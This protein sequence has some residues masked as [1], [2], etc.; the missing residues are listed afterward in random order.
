MIKL[1]KKY[2]ALNGIRNA[3]DGENIFIPIYMQQMFYNLVHQLKE[4][5]LILMNKGEYDLLFDE[6]KAE[7]MAVSLKQEKDISSL[8]LFEK[9]ILNIADNY[10]NP[11]SVLNKLCKITKNISKDENYQI[12]DPSQLR[13]KEL[14][15][16]EGALKFLFLMGFEYNKSKTLLICSSSPSSEC[17]SNAMNSFNVYRHNPY[18]TSLSPFM[19][20][21]INVR[22]IRFF[23]EFIW[24]FSEK[25][26]KKLK[27]SQSDQWLYSKEEYHYKYTKQT[28]IKFLLAICRE[29]SGSKYTGFLLK[30][31]SLPLVTINGKLNVSVADVGWFYCC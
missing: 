5:K 17:I 20:T 30:I 16:C 29:V 18:R 4:Q 15:S 3:E 23:Q 24:V 28:N 19:S 13:D 27:K 8:S 1:I 31:N 2:K 7:L 6:L 11:L 9:T 10:H 26:L 14:F 25:E 22:K 12:L 21:F